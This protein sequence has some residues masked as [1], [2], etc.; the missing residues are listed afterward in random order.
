MNFTPTLPKGLS[1][2]APNLSY[3]TQYTEALPFELG[4][5]ARS[6]NRL[7]NVR[8]QNTAK[9]S[10]SLN[11]VSIFR[12]QDADPD[13]TRR[14]NPLAG[15]SL[16]GKRLQDI[17]TSVAVTRNSGYDR[18]RDRPD[19]RYQFGIDEGPAD[20]IRETPIAGREERFD[21][22]KSVT[23]SA[24]GGVT[25][26]RGVVMSTQYSRSESRQ[27]QS[28]NRQAR[29][30]TT[31]PDVNVTWG[32]LERIR[33]IGKLVESASLDVGYKVSKEKGGADISRPDRETEHVDWSPLFSIAT[34]FESG[35]RANVTGNR[36]K[37]TSESGL[38]ARAKNESSNSNYRM[39]FEYRIKTARKVSMPLL[40]KGEATTFTSELGLNLDFNY[41]TAK[42]VSK[43][44]LPGQVDIVQGDTRSWSIVPRANYSFSRNVTGSLEARYGETN[45][46]KNAY[47]SRRTVGVSV[48]AT[49]TF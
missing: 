23:A 30:Q 36:S 11:I 5:D 42:D 1:W 19:L 44:T 37:S 27:V 22:S 13:T 31:W 38:G 18:V 26:I 9:L 40:G 6:G 49:L 28:R 8:N 15:L 39:G 43:A 46:Q 32:D 35:L 21:R 24:S 45:N 34:S 10:T 4:R 2:I 47:L 3:D 14:F 20:A 33:A 25:L 17:R 16:L 7:R 41:Q 12:N 48:S 29:S